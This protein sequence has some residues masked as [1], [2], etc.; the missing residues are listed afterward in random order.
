MNMLPQQLS[1]ERV[2]VD[3]YCKHYGKVGPCLR[4][5][6]SRVEYKR[7]AQSSKFPPNFHISIFRSH[8]SFPLYMI[9]EKLVATHIKLCGSFTLNTFL[10]FSQSKPIR[11]KFNPRLKRWQPKTNWNLKIYLTT[12]L[13]TAIFNQIPIWRIRTHPRFEIILHPLK[14]GFIRRRKTIG[15]ATFS[16]I[17]RTQGIGAHLRFGMIFHPVKKDLI[18]RW[19]YLVGWYIYLFPTNL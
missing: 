16:Q 4:F 15:W 8:C 17:V 18:R 13:R 12:Y 1:L 11:W 19:N 10:Y 14:K 7:I 5:R 9:M 2:K 6:C 3:L